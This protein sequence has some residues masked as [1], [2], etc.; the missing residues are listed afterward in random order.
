[1]GIKGDKR[2]EKLVN[3]NSLRPN[4]SKALLTQKIFVKYLVFKK[5]I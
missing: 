2:P 4:A 5:I 1:L 3:S